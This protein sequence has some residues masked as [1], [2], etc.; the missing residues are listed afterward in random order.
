MAHQSVW[1]KS[2]THQVALVQFSVNGVNVGNLGDGYAVY[3]FSSSFSVS[4]SNGIA[5]IGFDAGA[6]MQIGS[7]VDAL[8]SAV[9]LLQTAPAST[10]DPLVIHLTAET[11]GS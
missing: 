8:M 11:F 7:R 3:D 10:T 1:E 4:L 9:A 5:H 6:L 2:K